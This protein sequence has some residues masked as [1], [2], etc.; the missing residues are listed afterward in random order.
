MFVKHFVNILYFIQIL[1]WNKISSYMG[2]EFFKIRNCRSFVG[3][4]ARGERVANTP[5]GRSSF[6]G[7]TTRSHPSA[8][9]NAQMTNR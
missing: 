4:H 3:G 2:N 6:G 7:V 5:C 9:S 1:G 8:R